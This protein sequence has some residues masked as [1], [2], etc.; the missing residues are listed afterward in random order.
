MTCEIAHYVDGFGHGPNIFGCNMNEY[1]NIWHKEITF[2][3]GMLLKMA[4]HTI[5]YSLVL[6]KHSWQTIA[7]VKILT[8]LIYRSHLIIVCRVSFNF[9]LTLYSIHTFLVLLP[10][11]IKI[12]II[13]RLFLFLHKKLRTGIRVRGSALTCFCCLGIYKQDF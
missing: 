2:A 6:L 12:I 10:T 4:V 8:Q 5:L 13:I 9:N 1:I 7:V 3:H 11:I